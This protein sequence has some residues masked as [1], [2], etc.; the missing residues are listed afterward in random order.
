MAVARILGGLIQPVGGSQISKLGGNE[1]NVYIAKYS[2]RS[3][4]LFYGILFCR[5]FFF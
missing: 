2:A 5:W 4:M 1:T 3:N